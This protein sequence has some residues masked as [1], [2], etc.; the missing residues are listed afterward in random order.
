M[1]QI[2]DS[3]LKPCP[4]CGGTPELIERKIVKRSGFFVL[5]LSCGNRTSVWDKDHVIRCWNR[6]ANDARNTL[7]R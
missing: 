3:K 6:R 5:C 4:F 2:N 7:P 1:N